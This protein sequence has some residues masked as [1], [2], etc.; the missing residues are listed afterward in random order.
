LTG[1]EEEQTISKQWHSLLRQ[2]NKLRLSLLK[3]QEQRNKIAAEKSFKKDPNKFSQSIF[4]PPTQNAQPEFSAEEAQQYFQNTYTDINRDY[5]YSAHPEMSRP[6]LPSTIF[7]TR[8]PTIIELQKSA[9]RKRNGAAPGLNGLTYVPYKKCTALLKFVVKLGRK[10]WKKKDI[11]ADWARAYIILLAKSEDLKSL[12]EFRPIAITST[13][14]K[15]FFSVISDRLQFF[16]I[17][18]HYITR[19]LQKGF[20]FGV[21][22]CLEHSFTLMEALREAKECHQQIVVS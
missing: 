6:K 18:N 19:D 12:S 13:V 14:G 8:C 15:I 7:S 4:H 17:Q 9:K 1:T 22:V 3:K 16:M 2:H 20:L 10:I 11:P 5:I 21:P